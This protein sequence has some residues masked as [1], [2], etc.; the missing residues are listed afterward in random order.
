MGGGDISVYLDSLEES[1][2]K[3][4]VMVSL[5]ELKKK[6]GYFTSACRRIEILEKLR[7]K[8]ESALQT[9]VLENP[10]D[11]NEYNLQ[12][13][14]LDNCVDMDDLL[15]SVYQS[16]D[17]CILY[18]KDKEKFQKTNDS[19]IREMDEL[20]SD[21]LSLKEKEKLTITNESLIK[22]KDLEPKYSDMLDNTKTQEITKK[23][24]KLYKNFVESNKRIKGLLQEITG[25]KAITKPDSNKKIKDLIE[26]ITM[27]KDT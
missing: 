3:T 6:I 20:K 12:K 2:V 19:L 9:S 8:N 21:V 16:I 23:N 11:R 15:S 5:P 18:I 10:V 25:L 27:L 4:M 22:E 24:V 7:S 17:I 1:T 26:K 14:V 13:T